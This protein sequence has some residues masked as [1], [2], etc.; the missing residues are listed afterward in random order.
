MKTVLFED[1]AALYES[2]AAPLEEAVRQTFERFPTATGIFLHEVQMIARLAGQKTLCV[3]GP[4]QT[5]KSPP[6]GHFSIT[7]GTAGMGSAIA[8]FYRPQGW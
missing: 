1:L 5:F 7:G 4:E 6:E 3:F 8:V 2:E